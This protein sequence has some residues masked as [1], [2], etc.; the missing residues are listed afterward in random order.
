MTALFLRHIPPRMF[1]Q[2]NRVAL[3]IYAIVQALTGTIPGLLITSACLYWGVGAF[4]DIQPFTVGQLLIWF[5][6][7]NGEAKNGIST[8]LITVI[9]FFIVFRT[10]QVAWIKQARLS[11]LHLIA[12]EIEAYF[13]AASTALIEMS[14]WAESL[15]EAIAA[16][17]ELPVG[18]RES[19]LGQLKRVIDKRE[20]FESWREE[21]KRRWVKCGQFEGR[22]SSL[23]VSL[24]GT[25]ASLRACQDSFER[26]GTRM[27]L[28]APSKPPI[29]W[30]LAELGEY[31]DLAAWRRFAELCD[32][33][34]G[35]LTANSGLVRGALTT[36][37]L[38]RGPISALAMIKYMSQPGASEALAAL[39][40]PRRP[41]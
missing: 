10:S 15:V 30:E 2:I 38:D 29:G 28:R 21:F 1:Q 11:R 33:E 7:L 5:A 40:A 4:T 24:P 27:Y 14:L 18:E 13:S 16:L 37:L 32:E 34:R 25:I 26:V 19:K 35:T 17:E 3:L 22:Y 9:G 6:E 8:A 23:L 41:G 20:E 39:R 12:D 31:A 36:S